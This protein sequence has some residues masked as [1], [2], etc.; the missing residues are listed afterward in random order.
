MDVKAAVDWVLGNGST[1]LVAVLVL[2][3]LYLALSSAPAKRL[4]RVIEET[5]FT[6][7]QLALLATTSIVLSLVAGYTTFDGLRNFT[8]G[9]ML[10]LM[11]TIGIQGVMLVTAW[12]IGESFAVGMNQRG[13]RGTGGWDLVATGL[14]AALAMIAATLWF[15]QSTTYAADPA[16]S[17]FDGRTAQ[18]IQSFALYG[19]ITALAFALV[20]ATSP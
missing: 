5:F 3:L 2:S 18:S 19:A 12:L 9:G 14:F 15:G 20:I 4:V 8:G 17:W 10:S 7:W 6:N 16:G 13:Q 1:L 11:A